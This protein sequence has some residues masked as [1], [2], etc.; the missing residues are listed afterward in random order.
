MSTTVKKQNLT[1]N[2]FFDP[3]EQELITSI[4]Q[5]AVEESMGDVIA[6]KHAR[7]FMSTLQFLPDGEDI[8]LW[9]IINHHTADGLFEAINQ[10]WKEETSP[11]GQAALQDMAWKIQDYLY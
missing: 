10:L 7:G 4:I 2:T 1:I 8:E 6:M 9:A 11:D 3:E 5:K